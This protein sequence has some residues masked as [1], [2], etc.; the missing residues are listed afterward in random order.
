MILLIVY[1]TDWKGAM[2]EARVAHSF[3]SS[4]ERMIVGLNEVVRVETGM[5]KNG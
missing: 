2:T 5:V 3:T 4:G 1:T